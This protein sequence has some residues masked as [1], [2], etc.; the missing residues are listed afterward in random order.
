MT[1][2]H[3]E[4]EKN[5]NF[6]AKM[7]ETPV[8][9]IDPSDIRAFDAEIRRAGET[10][11]AGGLV[12]FPTETVYGLGANAFDPSA[13]KKI[14]EAKGR[15]SDNPLI[16]HVA[17][18]AQFHEVACCTPQ[19]Q[20][21]VERFWPGPLTVVLPKKDIVPFETT[22]GQQTVAVRFPKHSVALA[23]I[24]ASGCAIAAPSANSSGRPSPTKASHVQFDMDGKI[25]LIIDGGSS[26]FGLEST[27]V[28]MCGETP[29]LLRPG[30]ITLDMLEAVLGR[31]EIDR[32]LL[33]RFD[34]GSV[35]KAPGMK[36]AHYS[37]LA[38]VTVV[39]GELDAQVK[40]IT[41]LAEHAQGKAAIMATDQTAGCYDGRYIV[42]SVGDREKTETIAANLFRLLRKFDFLGADEIFCESFY[43]DSIGFS[44]MNR[45]EKSAG[46]RII[47]TGNIN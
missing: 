22:G 29:V 45:L 18:E 46:Y 6:A 37:P 36:Y 26:E 7:S 16:V 28:D 42:L 3:A 4:A 12:A 30:S 40:K 44:I 23:L 17:T 14:F 8:V 25:D 21:L 15:P 41:E 33:E 39:K 5:T 38:R 1:C 10:I 47:D 2:V 11:K 31:V 27:I 35:P 19:C 9:K 43:G 24:L 20:T 34:F 32:Y 13:V